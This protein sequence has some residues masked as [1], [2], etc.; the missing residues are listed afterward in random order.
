MDTL[1]LD[2]GVHRDGTAWISGEPAQVASAAGLAAASA[3]HRGG[4][5]TTPCCVAPAGVGAG[6]VPSRGGRTGL[7]GR[8]LDDG[9]GALLRYPVPAGA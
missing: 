4:P 6:F 5:S 2:V 3:D 1:L 8:P 9:V 7:V